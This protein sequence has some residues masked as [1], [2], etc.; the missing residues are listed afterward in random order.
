M[1]TVDEEFLAAA[2]DFMERKTKENVPWLEVVRRSGV[3]YALSTVVF[4]IYGYV[5]MLLS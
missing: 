3:P 5:A 1:E 4:P 2:V